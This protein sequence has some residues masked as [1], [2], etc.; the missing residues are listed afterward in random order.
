MLNQTVRFTRLVLNRAWWV[1]ALMIFVHLAAGAAF[2]IAEDKS[3]WDGQW[4]ASVTGFT[5]GYGDFF[6]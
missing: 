1:I 5:V 6:P 2:S 4:W 3:I